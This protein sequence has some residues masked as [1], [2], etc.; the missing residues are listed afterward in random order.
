MNKKDYKLD[1]FKSLDALA[2]CNKAY[3]SAL[4]HEEKKDFSPFVYM[5]WCSYATQS[6]LYS[7][8]LINEICNRNFNVIKDKE[9]QW[10]ILALASLS[11]TRFKWIKPIAGNTNATYDKCVLRVQQLYGVNEKEAE[12]IIN[13]SSSEELELLMNEEN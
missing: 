1:L 2:K 3:Y 7:C 13:N 8:I 4:S 10:K 5:R 9:L 12:I 6:P 11:K